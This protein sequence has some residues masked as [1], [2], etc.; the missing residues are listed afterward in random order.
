MNE[1]KLLFVKPTIIKSLLKNQLEKSIQQ[2]EKGFSLTEL[3]FVVLIIGILAAIATP[4]WLAFI[5][6]QRLRTSNDRIYQGMKTARSNAMR[7]KITWQASF[8]QQDGIVQW[9]VHPESLDAQKANWQNLE[10]GVKI[11]NETTMRQDSSTKIWRIKFNYKGHPNGLR[12]ITLSLRS[13]DK[14]KRCVFIST[15][16][17]AMRTAKDQAKPKGEKYCY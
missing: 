14:A 3:I 12:R 5:N 4:G 17:G 11:D 7:D 15:L 8:R 16:L 10:S 6:N 1:D 9:A 13:G 2:K